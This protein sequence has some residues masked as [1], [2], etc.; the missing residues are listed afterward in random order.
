M[1]IFRYILLNFF[2]LLI[3]TAFFEI[4]AF[5]NICNKYIKESS[6]ETVRMYPP[7][8]NIKN[9]YFPDNKSYASIDIFNLNF[10]NEEYLFRKEGENNDYNKPSIL[11]F[12]CSFAYGIGLDDNQSFAYKLSRI[13]ERPVY[14]R[15]V[16][17]SGIQYF[18][19][20]VTDGR[21]FDS[22]RVK[23][24]YAIYVYIP[25]HLE[26]IKKPFHGEL[27]AN[28][29]IRYKLEG[30]NLVLDKTLP[31]FLYKSALIK[32]ILMHNYYKMADSYTKKEM[33]DNFALI[34]ELFLQSKA[35][36]EKRYPGIK[37][38]ILKYNYDYGYEISE[39]PFLFDTLKDEGF[40][41]LDT[42]DL[43]GKT[44]DLSYTVSDKYHPNEAAWDLIVPKLVQKL[45]L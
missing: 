2:I 1:K 27:N 20:L 26:R 5:Y 12:G 4:T 6:E 28:L 45:K 18:Y 9:F 7:P 23:P 43:T 8:Q 41:V 34:N 44:F 10:D 15:A 42:K 32:T 39:I 38:V 29:N 25:E 14:N 21:I 40:I 17:A 31:L 37:T 19:Y 22:I 24:E 11:L 30:N 36:L 16:W 35:E 3:I 33:Y 13:T